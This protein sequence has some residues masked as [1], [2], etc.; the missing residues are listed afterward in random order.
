MD[1]IKHELVR[2]CDEKES[3][4]SRIAD[5]LL[6]YLPV[7]ETTACFAVVVTMTA[8]RGRAVVI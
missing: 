5:D 4:F 8:I 6:I 2:I 3:F 7:S 1:Q